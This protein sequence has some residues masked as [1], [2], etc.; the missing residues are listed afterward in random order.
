MSMI[1]ELSPEQQ[2]RVQEAAAKEGLRPDQWAIRK[3][4]SDLPEAPKLSTN[5]DPT[6][7]L[8]ARW[9]AEDATD[10]PAEI[11]KAEAELQELKDA[12]N[13]SRRLVGARLLFPE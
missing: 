9:A 7:E 3:M 11:R 13:E 6:L 1:I 2:A 5:G 8:F 4:L 12:L 10:D